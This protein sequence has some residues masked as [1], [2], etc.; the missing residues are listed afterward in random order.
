[1][2]NQFT[3]SDESPAGRRVRLTHEWVE[4]SASVP[5]AAP[6][7][8][9]SPADRGDVEGTDVVFQWQPAADPDGDKIADYPFELS[10][11][12]DMKWPLSMSFAKLI[13]RTS[14]AGS[15]RYALKTPG[16]LNPDREYYWHVRAKDAQG[17]WGPWSNTWSFTPR[18]PA[19]PLNVKLDYD[20]G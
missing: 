6:S 14:D 12:P 7:A 1:G 10:S 18:G 13:S 16:E 20:A 2:Q 17:V 5:P 11:R 4:R 15:A 8:P 19:P 3:Y 9:I